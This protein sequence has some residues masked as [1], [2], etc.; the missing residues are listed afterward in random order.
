M[1]LDKNNDQIVITYDGE[2][3]NVTIYLSAIASRIH[4]W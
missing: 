3:R 2:E 4:T 1:S